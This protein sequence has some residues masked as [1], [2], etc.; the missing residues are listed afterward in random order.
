MLPK[1]GLFSTNGKDADLQY[2]APMMSLGT[3]TNFSLCLVPW[4]G[5]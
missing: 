1:I 3:Y 2:C 5:C 4:T